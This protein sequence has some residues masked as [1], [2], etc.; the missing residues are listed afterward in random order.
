MFCPLSCIGEMSLI[1]NRVIKTHYPWIYPPPSPPP[2]IQKKITRTWISVQ[3]PHVTCLRQERPSFYMAST[4][5]F[6]TQHHS[7]QQLANSSRPLSHSEPSAATAESIRVARALLQMVRGVCSVSV[8]GRP[9]ELRGKT[10]DRSPKT[11]FGYGRHASGHFH[12]RGY[13]VMGDSLIRHLCP[14]VLSITKH[15]LSSNPQR[16]CPKIEY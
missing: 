3:Y 6:A 8:A 14:R 16:C 2:I 1:F 11:F 10:G 12:N 7:D 9:A 15:S 4:L 13:F 5:L